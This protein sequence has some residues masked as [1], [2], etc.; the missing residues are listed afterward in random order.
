MI[1]ISLGNSR[2]NQ[3]S[4]QKIGRNNQNQN[5]INEIKAN[6]NKSMKQKV[7]SLKR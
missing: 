4:K 7:D 2:T 6:K 3:T 5:K 1:H